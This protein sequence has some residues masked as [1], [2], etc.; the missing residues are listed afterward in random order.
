VTGE[1]EFVPTEADHLAAARLAWVRRVFSLRTSATW[2]L[3]IMI[4][5]PLAAVVTVLLDGAGNVMR[6]VP[7]F[8]P[9]VA[10]GML[11]TQLV[12]WIRLPFITRRL[13]RQQKSLHEAFRY[14]WSEEG[15]SYASASGSGLISWSSLYGWT[16]GKHCF[17]LYMNERL[18]QFLP[19]RVMTAGE[20]DDLVAA[21]AARC[22]RRL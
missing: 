22:V 6:Q 20:A 7:F 19:R 11:L 8:L 15:I 1:I 2:I 21:L 12:C 5:S 14:G 10:G 13:F 18:V 17:L 4:V 16:V 9:F 3:I